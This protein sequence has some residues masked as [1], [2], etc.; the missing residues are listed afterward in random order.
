MFA[1]SGSGK[2]KNTLSNAKAAKDLG[3]T[4]VGVTSKK[5]SP[6]AEVSDLVLE[7]PGK[8]K[9]D[10]GVSSIQLLSSLFDQSVHIVLD[11]L[12]LLM[13]RRDNLSDSEAAKNHIN[14][15]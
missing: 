9:N 12:C 11:D 5:D 3:L 13:S 8:T 4:I 1:I 15:E 7:V 14:V 10:T 2:T 6:L